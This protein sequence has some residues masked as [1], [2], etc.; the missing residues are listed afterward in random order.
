MARTDARPRHLRPFGFTTKI[1][2]KKQFILEVL[3]ATLEPLTR[4]EIEIALGWPE[5]SLYYSKNKS[6]DP[7]MHLIE[8]GKVGRRQEGT[9]RRYYADPD[10]AEMIVRK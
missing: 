10:I 3:R 2:E 8:E 9:T 7:I 1:D 6:M 4:Q 5:G